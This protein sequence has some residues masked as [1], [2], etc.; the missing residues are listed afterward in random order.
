MLTV[1]ASIGLGAAYGV[2]YTDV[3]I[4]QNAVVNILLFIRAVA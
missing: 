2:P 4:R 1:A 3:A